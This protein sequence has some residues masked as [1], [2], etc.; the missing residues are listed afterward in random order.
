MFDC[1]RLDHWWVP[2]PLRNS[3]IKFTYNPT[4]IPRTGSVF[5]TE[6]EARLLYGR[7][8][9]VGCD[10]LKR[11]EDGRGRARVGG[12]RGLNGLFFKI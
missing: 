7:K 3:D 4:V 12:E 1:I 11:E 8:M 5:L 2:S 6:E 9:G 10:S